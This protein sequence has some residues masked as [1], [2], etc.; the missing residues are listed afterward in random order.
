MSLSVAKFSTQL[1][2]LAPEFN[3]RSHEV[4]PRNVDMMMAELH[5]SHQRSPTHLPNARTTR[6]VVQ[7]N[8]RIPGTAK[9]QQARGFASGTTSTNVVPRIA[10]T[11]IPVQSRSQTGSLVEELT[12]HRNIGPRPTDRRWLLMHLL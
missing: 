1:W 4:S 6:Q 11:L 12:Q 2:H 3:C 5:L 8:G 7:A 9:R 10:G